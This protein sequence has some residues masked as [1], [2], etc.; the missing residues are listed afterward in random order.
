MH[1]LRP[2]P[3]LAILALLGRPVRVDGGVGAAWGLGGTTALPV[4][5]T[6]KEPRF[7]SHCRVA[8]MSRQWHWH[9]HLVRL[10]HP[11]APFIV[12]WHR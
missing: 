8:V 3:G 6:R 9:A 5:S 12:R 4:S 2:L 11:A 7:L 10:V 1:L